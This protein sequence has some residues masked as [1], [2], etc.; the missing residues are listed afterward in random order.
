MTDTTARVIAGIAAG[1]AA[2][3]MFVAYLTYRRLRPRLI[4]KLESLYDLEGSLTT[5]GRPHVV[6]KMR[7]VNRSASP[8]RIETF[9]L[10]LDLDTRGAKKRD[11][12]LGRCELEEP[13]VIEPMD[14]VQFSAHFDMQ[15]LN[16]HNLSVD[17]GRIEAV[18]SD[19]RRARRKLD[20]WTVTSLRVAYRK[21]KE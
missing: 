9:W 13:L 19:G 11:Y 6:A 18:L 15:R 1:A 14:G 20:E 8:A 3:S 10:R 2:I 16:L 17:S 21:S 5:D 12:G 7:L 4:I